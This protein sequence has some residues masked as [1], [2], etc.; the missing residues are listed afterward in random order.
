MDKYDMYIPTRTLFGAG[1]LRV[2]HEQPM[3]GKKA[4]IVISNGKST[5]LNGYLSKTEN[6]LEVAGVEYVLFDQVESNPL[7]STVM[8]G[9]HIARGSHCDFIVA[10]GDGSVMDASKGIAVAAT[11]EGDIWNYIQSGTGG[12]KPIVNQPLPIIAITT[13]AGTGSETDAG[14]VISNDITHEKI[15]L[16]DIRLFPKLAL[17]D[18][19]LM[20]TVPSKYTAYQGFDALFHSVE[21]YVSKAANPMSDMYALTAIEHISRYLPV[22]VKDGTDLE[23]REHVAFGNTLSGTVMCVGSTTSQHSLEHAMSAYHQNLPHGAGLIMIS[24]A[25]FSHLVNSR[26]CDDRF[27]RLAKVMGKEDADKPEDFIT[28]LRLLQEECGVASLKMSDY[29]ISPEEF[30]KF[31][32]NAKTT[33]G[34]LFLCDRVDLTDADCVAIFQ[35]SYK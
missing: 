9:S 3:P 21:G 17:V 19:E 8:K 29:G 33:M 27:I 20:L 16:V 23:A 2:L 34:K 35:A 6:E 15:G 31:T 5:K 11:N 1:S 14:G 25:Y 30:R 4:L 24:I 18:P 32:A 22:A 10:L 7:S 12:R 28:Q 26:A 13:T